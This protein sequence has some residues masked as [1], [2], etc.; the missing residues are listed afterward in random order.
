S[1]PAHHRAL[2]HLHADRKSPSQSGRSRPQQPVSPGVQ[3]QTKLV[4]LG[5]VARRAVSRELALPCLDVVLGL[6]ARAG[7]KMIFDTKVARQLSRAERGAMD[8]AVGGVAMARQSGDRLRAGL[9]GNWSKARVHATA[10]WSRLQ[11]R[12]AV[13]NQGAPG[14]DCKGQTL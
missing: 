7:T 8:W 3:E 11:D 4:G 2:T 13:L 14:M 5:R 12:M 1:Q 6:T 9:E 10:G